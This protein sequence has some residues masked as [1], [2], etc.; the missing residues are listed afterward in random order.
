MAALKTGA[1]QSALDLHDGRLETVPT[2]TRTDIIQTRLFYRCVY[3]LP[4]YFLGTNAQTHI[5][6]G[7]VTCHCSC[8]GQNFYVYFAMKPAFFNRS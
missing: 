1:D 2:T 4:S 5:T 7:T 8:R 3:I 6:F